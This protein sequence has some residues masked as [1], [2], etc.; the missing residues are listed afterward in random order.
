M[1]K[2][3][4]QLNPKIVSCILHLITVPAFS[5]KTLTMT[6][7][8]SGKCNTSNKAVLAWVEEL[9]KHCKPDRVYWCNGSK[10]ER[11]ALLA[12]AVEKGV[13]IKL[14]Q[15]KRPGCYYHRSNPNDVARV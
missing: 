14:N 5:T 3:Q 8:M 11:K 7:E 15:K 10:A 6:K 13:L 1:A 9:A 2:A 12:E 4:C